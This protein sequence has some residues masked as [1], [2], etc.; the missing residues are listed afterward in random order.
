M[1][2]VVMGRYHNQRHRREDQKAGTHY[3]ITDTDR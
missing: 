2:E 1:D 3:S